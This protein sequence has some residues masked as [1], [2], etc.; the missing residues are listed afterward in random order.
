MPKTIP[1][2]LHGSTRIDTDEWIS[3][4]CF[5]VLSR[6]VPT[7]GWRLVPISS[8]ENRTGSWAH[9][10]DRAPASTRA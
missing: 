9:L 1:R 6:I 3:V 7:F 2:S 8:R 5:C 4:C 10:R